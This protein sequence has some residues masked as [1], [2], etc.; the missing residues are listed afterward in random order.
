MKSSLRELL[1][2]IWGKNIPGRTY[3]YSK[4]QETAKFQEIEKKLVRLQQREGRREA[5]SGSKVPEKNEAGVGD[6]HGWLRGE[7]V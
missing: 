7:G 3:V 4:S 2:R 1:I 6:K 5:E